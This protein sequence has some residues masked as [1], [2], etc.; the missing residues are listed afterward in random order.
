MLGSDDEHTTTRPVQSCQDHSQRIIGRE[1]YGWFGIVHR[2]AVLQFTC[3]HNVR[4]YSALC[5]ALSALL[6]APRSCHSQ[7]RQGGIVMTVLTILIGT[8]LSFAVPLP[9]FLSLGAKTY[10]PTGRAASPPPPQGFAAH[11]PKLLLSPFRTEADMGKH[12][13]NTSCHRGSPMKNSS[14][15]SCLGRE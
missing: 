7:C 3:M 14:S 10:G 5:R 12:L 13:R 1:F 8:N 2:P 9:P 11:R 15:T 6:P 4:Q